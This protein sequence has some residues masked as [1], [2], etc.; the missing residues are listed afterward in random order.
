MLFERHAQF[1]SAFDN[2]LPVDAAREGFVLHLLFHAGGVHFKDA[3]IGFHVGDG[4]DEPCQLVAGV[5]HLFERGN[6]RHAAVVGV[7]EDRAA[8]LFVHSA[9][10][11][12][13]LAQHRMVGGLRVNLPIEIVE[14]RGE[15]PLVFVLAKLAGVG[16]DAGLYRQS[17]LAESFG[18]GEFA[19][20]VPGLFT[21]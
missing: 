3:A 19:D 13:R 15:A 17:V 14:Q 16:G 5:E 1:L 7:R 10:G 11:Q 12:H 4:G 6:A 8:D 20:D 2:V 21:S 18:F 9:L